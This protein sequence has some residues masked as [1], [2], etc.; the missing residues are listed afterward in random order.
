MQLALH[1]S[2]LALAGSG[3]C[4]V[5]QCACVGP[6]WLLTYPSHLITTPPSI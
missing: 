5:L 1:P 3:A 2:E 6:P 4:C